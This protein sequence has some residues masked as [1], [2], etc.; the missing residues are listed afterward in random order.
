MIIFPQQ[1]LLSINWDRRILWKNQD[2]AVYTYWS[3]PCIS[4]RKTVRHLRII[5]SL[6]VTAASCTSQPKSILQISS[7]HI[8]AKSSFSLGW[9]LRATVFV[10][11]VCNIP[12]PYQV[13]F[14]NL[15]I[16]YTACPRTSG[17]RQMECLPTNSVLK[18]VVIVK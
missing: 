5:D 12:V 4:I 16:A 11:D 18:K 7:L 2:I 17:P 14:V 6:A 9:L 8:L 15:N 3:A 10:E 13:K 1:N